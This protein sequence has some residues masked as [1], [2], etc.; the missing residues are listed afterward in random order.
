[1]KRYNINRC[2]K[3]RKNQTDTEGN[4]WS[5]LRNRQLSGIK[6]RRQFAIG[7]NILDFYSPEHKLGIEADG[8]QYYED[9]GKKQDEVRAKELASYGIR[10][11]RFSD[12]DILNNIEGVYETIQGVIGDKKVMSPHLNSLPFRGEESMGVKIKNGKIYDKK[13]DSRRADL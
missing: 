10:I 8:G 5:I 1:M 6:F 9:M 2:R 12:F 7:S 4:L 13:E 3:L 11:V